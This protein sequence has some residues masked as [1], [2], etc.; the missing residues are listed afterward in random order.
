MVDQSKNN[1]LYGKHDEFFR[2]IYSSPRFARDLIE[3]ALSQ[4]T[5]DL[6][7]LDQIRSERERFRDKTADLVFSVPLKSNGEENCRFFI[8]IEHKSSCDPK[9]LFRQIF[10][11]Q[12]GF[13]EQSLR[14]RINPPSIDSLGF[15]PWREFLEGRGIVSGGSLGGSFYKVGRSWFFR[16]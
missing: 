16:E 8:L 11:Y 4:K 13:Y 2:R 3:L 10:S 7:D 15:L 5:L 6:L 14:E 1:T 9:G 12:C